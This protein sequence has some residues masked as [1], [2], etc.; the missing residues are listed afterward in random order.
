MTQQLRRNFELKKAAI[1]LYRDG[2]TEGEMVQH[3][4]RLKEIHRLASA[5]DS[6]NQSN[7]NRWINSAKEGDPDLEIWHLLNRRRKWPGLYNDWGIDGKIILSPY[8]D[9]LTDTLYL[10]PGMDYIPIGER[11]PGQTVRRDPAWRDRLHKWRMNDSDAIEPYVSELASLGYSLRDIVSLWKGVK[12][13]HQDLDKAPRVQWLVKQL[14]GVRQKAMSYTTIGR[15]L[16]VYSVGP[17]SESDKI[18][19]MAEEGEPL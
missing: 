14:K 6:L 19:Q 4:G 16:R 12:T 5:W 10:G 15:I 8:Y 13:R 3:K 17:V 1:Q 2:H 11:K 7:L 9:P 18:T